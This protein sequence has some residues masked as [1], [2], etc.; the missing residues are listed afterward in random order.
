MT[1]VKEYASKIIFRNKEHKDFY[2]K[3][4][5]KCIYQDESHK[6]LVYCLGIGEDTRENVDRIYDFKTGR[7]KTECLNEG[8]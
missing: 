3:Y 6:A 5:Q 4:L 1:R 2:L 7:V 8:W